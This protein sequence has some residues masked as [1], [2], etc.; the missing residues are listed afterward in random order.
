MVGNLHRVNH[1]RPREHHILFSA[2]RRGHVV[3]IWVFPG[4]IGDVVGGGSRGA[5]GYIQMPPVS[6][7]KRPRR[8]FRHLRSRKSK[9]FFLNK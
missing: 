7:E 3:P 1:N 2:I 5:M 9:T 4:F 8:P 6:N